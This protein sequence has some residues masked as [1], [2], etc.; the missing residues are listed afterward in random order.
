VGCIG[1]LVDQVAQLRFQ[2]RLAAGDEAVRHPARLDRFDALRH[3]TRATLEDALTGFKGE[4]EAIE[5]WVALLEPVD[6]A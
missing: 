1:D 5:C 3:R 6:H 2:A 4:I